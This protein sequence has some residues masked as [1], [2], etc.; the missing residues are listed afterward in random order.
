MKF[1]R[2]CVL[3]ALVAA[4]AAPTALALSWPLCEDGAPVWMTE[5]P[6]VSSE[7]PGANLWFFCREGPNVNGAPL[8]ACYNDT[9]CEGQAAADAFCKLIG[10]DRVADQSFGGWSVGALNST[11]PAL[12]FTGEYCLT[13]GVYTDDRLSAIES[14]RSENASAADATPCQVLTSVTCVREIATMQA[15][16]EEGGV[17]LPASSDTEVS[18]ASVATDG[19]NR[20]L[21]LP[22]R[23]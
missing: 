11:M 17:E 8:D 7:F 15:A 1:S 9:A 4:C 5:R 3:L 18:S 6:S 13:K 22:R 19:G 16:L 2:V 23:R 12:S 10:Y 14:V 20:K 21:L